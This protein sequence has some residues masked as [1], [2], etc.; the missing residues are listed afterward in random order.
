VVTS[1]KTLRA[2]SQLLIKRLNAYAAVRWGWPHSFSNNLVESTN[3]YKRPLYL[4]YE[5]IAYEI[6]K[7]HDRL[8]FNQEGLSALAGQMNLSIAGLD[9]A[10]NKIPFLTEK[11][12]IEF[13]DP[14]SGEVFDNWK[15]YLAK[16]KLF[17]PIVWI[18]D[19]KTFNLVPSPTEQNQEGW[20][21]AACIMLI[22][23]IRSQPQRLKI[24][25][26][27]LYLFWDTSKNGDR[28]HCG[29]S[30][31]IKKR[32]IQKQLRHRHAKTIKKL[33]A[34][35]S[36]L[37]QSTAEEL[38]ELWRQTFPGRQPQLS[39]T[40]QKPKPAPVRRSTKRRRK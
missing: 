30:A 4:I 2:E 37:N 40:S 24:C 32:N 39:K 27:C 1:I 15:D 35:K 12:N 31:C 23:D 10:V 20:A 9:Y 19:T 33:A 6:L 34:L 36:K 13:K 17:K 18:I 22:Q 26:Y 7:G 21:W 25:P 5:T 16:G 14:D 29:E 28:K 3:R 8:Q 11:L 38:L